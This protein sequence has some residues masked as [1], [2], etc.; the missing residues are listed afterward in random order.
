MTCDQLR[1]VMDAPL[2][3]TI[4]STQRLWQGGEEQALQLAV[5]LRE[6]GHT[7]R[8]IALA[9]RPFAERLAAVGFAVLPLRGKLPWPWRLAG[10]RGAVRKWGTQVVFC[11]DAH[12]LTLGGLAVWRMEQVVTVGARRASFPLRS[13]GRYRLLC[14]RVF[15]VSQAAWQRCFEAGI[16]ATQLR[17]VH[18]GVDPRR[19]A[20][21]D[22]LRG[23]DSLRAG[24]EELLLLSVGSLV[25]CKGHRVLIA[26]MPSVLQRFP[27]ARLA[28][29]GGGDQESALRQQ[30]AQLNLSS[31]VELLGFRHDVPDL[32]HA[33][34]LFVFPS[35]D[36]GLGSTLIDAMLAERAIVTTDAGGIPEVVG[37]AA[38]GQPQIAQIV[39]R[40]NVDALS[41]AIVA[42]LSDPDTAR[43]GAARTTTGVGPVHGRSH[44][45]IHD[46][47]VSRRDQ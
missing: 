25:P 22:R 41:E 2:R 19:V 21:G 27:H 32:L 33:C 23:R 26:A 43:A 40:G 13:P 29:A 6:R 16:A 10:L 18:D 4:V 17:V 34:D 11:N 28:I 44:G 20:A 5:G 45:G 47:R 31:R 35:L 8:V 12:A 15:C 30:I 46:R 9:G 37:S 3:V 7:C 38:E 14:D 24:P 39:P 42:A 36:E 1:R